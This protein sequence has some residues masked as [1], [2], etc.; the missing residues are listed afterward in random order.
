M[1]MNNSSTYLKTFIITLFSSLAFHANAGWDVQLEAEFKDFKEDRVT[2][3]E[4]RLRY[5]DG[6]FS[7]YLEYEYTPLDDA[8]DLEKLTWQFAYN[9]VLS[10]KSNFTLIHE[11]ERNL[12]S[13]I[14]SAE[15]TP[16]YYTTLDNGLIIGFELE[17]DYLNDDKFDIYELEIE[18]TLKWAK[19]VNHGNFSLE[20]EAPVMRL[21][22]SQPAQKNFE[23]E[24]ILTILGYQRSLS[25]QAVLN[26][27]VELPY[28][29]QTDELDSVVN[30]S[31]GYSF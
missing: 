12:S 3:Y 16:T 25:K 6:N 28:N 17:I 22:S 24:E 9:W 31:L 13:D 15:L 27:S 1:I 11:L 18:P 2:A 30:I 21:Y 4:P 10:E 29:L 7:T 19:K 8:K 26:A 5:K 20:L 23:F 14:N